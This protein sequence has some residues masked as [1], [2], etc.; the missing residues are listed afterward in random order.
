MNSRDW[1]RDWIAAELGGL[2]G[3]IQLWARSL[4]VI[5]RGKSC[6]TT[7]DSVKSELSSLSLT[8]EH[9]QT[10]MVKRNSLGER[11]G[12]CQSSCFTTDRPASLCITL[13]HYRYFLPFLNHGFPEERL[14]FGGS[15]L[16]GFFVLITHARWFGCDSCTGSNQA[17][18]S[19]EASSS[20]FPSFCSSSPLSVAGS[21]SRFYNVTRKRRFYN[22]LRDQQALSCF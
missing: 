3:A 13:R 2:N 8:Y 22:R 1:G 17:P 19:I 5:W 6:T 9:V 7:E 21:P 16:V 12:H 11:F 14:I 20:H 10:P 18:L 15:F 4:V